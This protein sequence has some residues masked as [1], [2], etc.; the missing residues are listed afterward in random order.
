MA[1]R[2]IKSINISALEKIP[3]SSVCVDV[4]QRFI[5]VFG[6]KY[7]QDPNEEDTERLMMHNAKG[8]WLGMLRSVDCMHLRWKS[9]ASWHRM[10]TTHQ[11]NPTILLEAATSNELWIWHCLF[12]MP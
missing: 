11:R 4:C 8:G 10:Y 3:S 1:F 12:G 7:H 5:W 9:P 2:L 6:A